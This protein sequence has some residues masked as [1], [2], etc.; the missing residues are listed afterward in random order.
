[1]S[2][3]YMEEFESDEYSDIPAAPVI[4]NA[5]KR[6]PRAKAKA[7]AKAKDEDEDESS[8]PPQFLEAC[9]AMTVAQRAEFTKK[10][11]E[12]RI[13][14]RSLKQS[15]K[16]LLFINHFTMSGVN[17]AFNKTVVEE[18]GEFMFEHYTFALKWKGLNGVIP[19]P[20]KPEAFLDL[21]FPF[22]LEDFMITAKKVAAAKLRKIVCF[23]FVFVF[24]N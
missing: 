6:K 23:V 11:I 5:K 13:A 7:N 12:F 19:I 14:G 15:Q 20:A 18:E 2:D 4:V 21:R 8:A 9:L 24:V 10:G 1:M 3:F 17:E 22:G 16:H